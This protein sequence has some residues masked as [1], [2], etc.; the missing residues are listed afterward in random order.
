MD[1]FQKE[2]E[3]VI[4]ELKSNEEMGLT[5]AEAE[6]RILRYG[7]NTFS[8]KEK[9]SIFVKILES[10]KEPLIVIL[11][12]SGLISLAMGHLADG[13]GIFVAVLIA[14][15]IAVI[16]EGKSDKAFEALSKL[17][18]D[19]HVKVVRESK[20]VYLSQ[21][22]LTIGD[23]IH[24]ET[25]DKVPADARLIHSSNLGIDESMLTGEAEAASKKSDKIDREDCPLAERKNM[26]YSGTMVTEGRVVAIVTSIG[27]QTEMG[28]I[29]NELKEEISSDTPL[30]QK[31]AD[32]GKRISIIGSI[33]AA[34]I[35][36]FE[37]FTMYRHGILVLDNIGAALPGIKDAFV[38]SVALIVAA[39]P[40][41]LPTMVAITLA[42]NMQKMA[43]NNALVRKLIACETIG[44]VNVVCSDKTGTLTENKMTVVEV[45]CDGKSVPVDKLHCDEMI[46]NFCVNS[47]ADITKN[48]DKYEF[49]GNPTECSL[50]VCADKNNI[51]YLH[52]RKEF[53]EPVS[54]Y[55]FT[56]AR[57]MMSTAYQREKG[58]RLYTK[59]SPEKVLNICNRILYNGSIVPM[60]EEHIKEIEANIRT[61]QDNARRVLAFAFNDFAQE[62]QWEDIYNVE[63]DLV[64]TGFIGIEDPLRSDVK[65][66]IDQCRRAGI[67]VKI[68]T[69]DNIN[70]ARAIANQLGLIKNDSLVLE[71]T[72]IDNMSDQEL[73][74]K[75]PKIV[76]I[77]RSNPT[78]KMRVVK[79]LKE[80]ND[81]VVVTGDGINDAPALKAADVGVAMG[82]AGTEVS[83]EA[84]DIVLLDDSFSTIVSAI[85][86]GR[87]IYENFQRFIQF[88]L[89]VNV[90]A[91]VTVILAE[92]MGYKMPFT[93]LQLL[94]VNI[95]MDGPP[96][97]TLG[98]EPPREHLLEKQPIKR[99]ASIV[100][101][102]MLLK[103]LSNGLFIVTALLM[104]MKT[105][106]LG[107]TEAQQSTIV[108]TSFV[109]FQLWNAFNSREF[110]VT[111][112]FPNIHRN[113]LMVGVVFL[114]FLVQI[115]VTQFGGQVFK[116]VP[117]EAAL[118]FKIIAFTFSIILFS[119]FLKLLMRGFRGI[120][121]NPQKD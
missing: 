59:G 1:Y 56:S 103:I 37:V 30:Q 115:L 66:A 68:L 51:N 6:A 121:S 33:A 40:E 10:L 74:S 118:W 19:V 57:K 38:T 91:F 95:I 28:K 64:Y 110:G 47:T 101:K 77:A 109:L 86:W 99:N 9:E 102:D 39:V 7:K 84:A 88:Q 89:T 14:T 2:V 108:F 48:N 72:D 83:K 87:G 17:S 65:D 43:K 96:A 44:S 97:L 49:L 41:G 60:T 111:S 90:V 25:G 31:L 92:L 119:E 69:G 32:L 8:P 79:L 94:W 11:L 112:I 114:T 62:P 81:S 104:L 45:W 12:I 58:F 29:A 78:A 85:K 20:I 21:S 80:S 76:V 18:E 35:F 34:G 98:L 71:V 54:E 107:G 26:L 63:K 67:T 105:Q 93:T 75:L 3:D 5:A 106:I 23:I 15:S 120:F 4:L 13:I 52:Y 117:L 55:N 82:I 22:D 42:F 53:G 100:T 113:K 16:Q 24:L 116:T 70:T 46:Q 36:L 61:L 73:K 50:L 27:D